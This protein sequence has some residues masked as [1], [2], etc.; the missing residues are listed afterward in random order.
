MSIHQT[1][2]KIEEGEFGG[3]EC[4]RLEIDH[5]TYITFDEVGGYS[6]VFLLR[7]DGEQ[8]AHLKEHRIPRETKVRL[9]EIEG[10]GR[11][12]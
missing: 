6:G 9:R 8:K 10:E 1:S 2:Y 4:Y 3:G 12:R 11:E 5:A 7:R